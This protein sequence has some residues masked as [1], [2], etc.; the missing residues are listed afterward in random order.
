MKPYVTAVIALLLPN[1]LAIRL[2]NFLGHK[3]SKK[4]Y[5]GRSWIQCD[6]IIMDQHSRIGHYN[7]IRIDKLELGVQASIRSYNRMKGPFN[8]NM[9]REAAI[10]NSNN[11]YRGPFPISSGAAHLWLGRLA[12]ITSKHQFDCTKSIRIGN[13]S[14]ISGFGT[15]LWTHGFYHAE[16]G[17]K[18]IRIDGPICIG[19]NVSVGSR[20]LLNPGIEI[21]DAINVGGNA[22]VSKSIHEA[23]MYV[24]QALRYIPNDIES[25]KSKLRKNHENKFVD[26]YE[27]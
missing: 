20:C 21:G 13:Y 9:A 15:Q 2:L 17:R 27:K 11:L 18:R 7:L 22:C 1:F 8:L 19:N 12:I 23:G 4:A 16:Q 24:S 3:I 5:I 10:G 26:V 6:E 25:I 14:T